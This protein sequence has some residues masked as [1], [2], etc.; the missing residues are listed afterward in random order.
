MR[1]PQRRC[2]TIA[3]IGRPNVGKS[4]LLNTI[5]GEKLSI[6][7]R[8]PQTTRHRILGIHTEESVQYVFVDTPGMQV[9]PR[10]AMNQLMNRSA[11][12]VLDEVNVVLFLVAPHQ[13]AEQERTLVKRLQATSAQVVVVVNK[14]DLEKQKQRLLPFMDQLS[15]ET[16][17]QWPLVPL[18]ARNGKG[19]ETLKTELG[20]LLPAGEFYYD[21]DTLTDRSERFFTA[22]IIREKL[23]RQLGEE[24][25]YQLT[26]VVERF[27]DPPEEGTVVIHAT[28]LVERQAQKTM[29][30][31]RQGNKLKAIGSSA[32]VDIEKML[33]KQVYLDLW[34]KVKTGWSNNIETLK[35]LGYE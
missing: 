3:L 25:P 33:E 24:L 26:V 19:V 28:I 20:H 16:G 23:M 2:G 30:I 12:S 29:I 4:T 5:L 1:E 22:E 6:T 31:G 17:N 10:V 8:K 13:W 7:C 14:V 35:N 15:R 9:Q 34:V 32:R 18:C 21:P 11:A 27:E